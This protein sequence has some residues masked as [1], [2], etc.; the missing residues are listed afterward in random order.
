MLQSRYCTG[1]EW[2]KVEISDAYYGLGHPPKSKGPLS[3]KLVKNPLNG[4]SDRLFGAQVPWHCPS[5]SASS[6]VRLERCC[7]R[8]RR[9]DIRR[10]GEERHRDDHQH[11]LDP[12]TNVS[13]KVQHEG[14]QMR[15]LQT[16]AGH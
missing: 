3:P 14:T 12:Q 15:G 5:A 1:G 11:H 8:Q 10:E 16:L 9:L 2:R 4:P 7:V 13:S 6:S